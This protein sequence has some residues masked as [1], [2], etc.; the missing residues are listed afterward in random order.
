MAGLVHVYT[1]NGKGKTTSALGLCFRALGRGFTVHFIQFMK[2]DPDYG[3]IRSATI[4]SEMHVKQF[5]TGSFIQKRD[6]S[7][8]D[9]RLA[10]D[11]LGHAR[12]V[13]ELLPNKGKNALI[14]LDELNVAL[15]F[16]LV[17]LED[18][19]RLIRE[20]P[21]ELELVI[22]GRGA[23]PEIIEIADYVTEMREIKH[24]YQKG[25]MARKGIEH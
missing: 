19:I 18:V 24:P 1:G 10:E 22:T 17:T 12:K 11:G 3:E 9:I 23:R 21:T 4:I 14:V 6:P 16:E 25:I 13:M 2:G 15:H 5:G 20:R 8:E 7:N